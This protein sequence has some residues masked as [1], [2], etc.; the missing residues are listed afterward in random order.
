[1]IVHFIRHAQAI[2]RC[3]AV[4]DEHRYLTCRGRKRFR[5][6]SGVLRKFDIDPEYIFTSPKIRAVQ[7]ADILA[8]KLLFSGEVIVTPLLSDFNVQSLHKILQLYP[9]P[10]EIVLVGHDPDF[11]N[12]VGHLL[13]L[14]SCV[15]TKG[16]VVTLNISANQSTLSAS[17]SSLI[18]GGGKVINARSKAIARLQTNNLKSIEGEN[19]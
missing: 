17:I 5:M 11:S 14:S 19:E 10:K 15:I 13:K 4:P 8:E 16:S 3:S 9:L 2:S 18:T 12:V 7:T 1:M 6:I